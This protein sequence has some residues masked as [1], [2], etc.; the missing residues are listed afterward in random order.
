MN[1]EVGFF[2]NNVFKELA[3]R[4]DRGKVLLQV[5]TE[6]DP[7]DEDFYKIRQGIGLDLLISQILV[8]DRKIL[9]PKMNPHVI[10][11]SNF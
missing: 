10:T 2:D 11:M 5:F 1:F 3:V 4:C 9:K 7:L 8:K 6:N